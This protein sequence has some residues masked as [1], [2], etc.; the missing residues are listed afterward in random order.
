MGVE[1]GPDRR[2]A[3]RNPAEP[4]ERRADAVVALARLRRVAAELLTERDGNG[5]HQVRPARLD[6]VDRELVAE[7]SRGDTVGG[8]GDALGLVGIE[9]AELRVDP[10]GGGLDPA[11][12]PRDRSRNRLAGDR[13]VVDR[14]ARLAAPEL[15]ARLGRHESR[16]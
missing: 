3:E 11:E 9:Q 16:V 10:S 5:V 6:D 2:A 7:L 13:K 14:L 4:L 15:P 8:G 12:P 1:A